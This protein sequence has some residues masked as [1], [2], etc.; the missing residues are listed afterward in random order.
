[1]TPQGGVVYDY[2]VK[3]NQQRLN[4]IIGQLE[5]IKKMMDSKADCLKILTQIK[6]TSS[7]LSAVMDSVVE[8]KF[9][10]CLKSLS[11][12]DKK[13]F[14]NLKKYVKSN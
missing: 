6:A 2:Q 12:D 1:L 14:I 10:T 13:L 7:A 9:N 4:N 11:K 5:G 8:D 3:T